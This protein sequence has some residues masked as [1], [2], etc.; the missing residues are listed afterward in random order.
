VRLLSRSL[1]LVGAAFSGAVLAAT[2]TATATPPQVGAP[3]YFVQSGVD[4]TVLAQKAAST[5]RA[6]ASITKLMTVLVALEHLSLDDVVTVPVLA[7]KVGEASVPLRAGQRITVRELVEAA[8]V[9]SANDAATTL[10]YAAAGGS[11]PR[12]VSWMNTKAAEI[13]LRDTHFVTPHGLDRPG[14]VSTARDIVK[15]ARV[16]L[17]NPVILHYAS[18][19][20]AEIAGHELETTDDLLSLFPPLVAGK[21]GHTDEA[22][23]TEVAEAQRGS[24]RIFASV[25]GDPS[26][27]QRNVDLRALLAWGLARYQRVLA[28]DASRVYAVAPTAYGRPAV[29]LV[30]ARSVARAQLDYRPLVE[31]IVAPTAVA[32]PVARGQRLGEVRIYERGRLVA[33]TPLVAAESIARPDALGRVRW[34]ATRTLHRLTS[35]FP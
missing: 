5:P 23:W 1:A 15:L 21:T 30:A 35:F 18:S 31:Q 3:A 16:A 6:I 9:P 14:H 34:Y 29:H 12:F 17:A 27:Y 10:A 24:V 33:A 4:G 8:L 13:G 26:R 11:V 32:L 28:I 7:T 2:G 20:S 25:L 22:G 19:E